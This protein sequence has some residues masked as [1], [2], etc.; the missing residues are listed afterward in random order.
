MT[1]IMLKLQQSWIFSLYCL[2]ICK[3]SI[4]KLLHTFTLW[5]WNYRD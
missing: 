1:G 2:P 3:Y 4:S 5:R